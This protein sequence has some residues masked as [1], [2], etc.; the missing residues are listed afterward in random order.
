MM[1]TLFTPIN[2]IERIDFEK[3]LYTDLQMR[4]F[5]TGEVQSMEDA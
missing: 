3:I 5:E 1:T 4:L 2:Q